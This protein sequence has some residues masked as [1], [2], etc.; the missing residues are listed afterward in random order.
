MKTT[1]GQTPLTEMESAATEV[2]QVPP[3][4]PAEMGSVDQ[5]SEQTEA[6]ES[7]HWLVDTYSNMFGK[8]QKKHIASDESQIQLVGRHHPGLPVLT[9][10]Q[11]QCWPNTPSSSCWGGKW[12][13]SAKST[14][15]TN[16]HV[17]K[18]GKQTPERRL[19]LSPEG[20]LSAEP[21]LAHRLASKPEKSPGEEEETLRN[22]DEGLRAEATVAS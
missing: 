4:M 21:G 22:G 20:A 19:L 18:R 12:R 5:G 1:R 7:C 6:V 11:K 15:E 14:P 10:Q 17:A 2:M 8:I 9:A 16:T 3:R 13:T